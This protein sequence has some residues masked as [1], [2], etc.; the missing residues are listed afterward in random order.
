VL[1][2]SIRDYDELLR[3]RPSGDPPRR[4]ATEDGERIVFQVWD[5]L[6]DDRYSVRH[7]IVE[8]NHG[9]WR[10]SERNTTY[11]ALT[12]AALS[13]ALRRAGFED[14]VWRMPQETG[15]YQPVVVARAA[16]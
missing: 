11:R 7:F 14:V 13:D 12:R 15:Y 9:C 3:E 1:L 5:W 8:S 4:F 10:V 6:C 16:G 2:A